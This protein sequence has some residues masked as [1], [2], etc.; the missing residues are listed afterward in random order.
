MSRTFV[1]LNPH[2]GKGRGRKIEPRI[3]EIFGAQG[4]EFGLT[5][6][7][8]DEERLTASAIASGFDRI[9]AV[10][11]D[12]TTSNIGHAIMESGRPVALGLVPGGTGCDL[13]RSLDIPQNDLVRCAE[14][15]AAGRV[16]SIDVGRV[17]GRHFLNVAGFG[18][19][20]AVLERSFQVRWLR[21]EL[22]YLYCALLEMKAYPGFALRSVLDDG[23]GPSGTHMMVIVANAR[24]FGGGFAIA[25]EASLDDGAL[26][27]VSFGDLGFFARL[28]AMSALIKGRHN[29]LPGIATTRARR[30]AFEFTAPPTFETD[31]EWRQ[32]KSASLIIETLPK[33]LRVLVP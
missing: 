30:A 12:G 25:P 6:Q 32:A 19:D 28:K 20:M 10:G 27:I 26:D 5:A 2:S 8:G 16:R 7:A 14:I 15:I 17:E 22:L 13:A 23:P 4:A 29:G 21:G 33:A 1:I 24:K 18:F 9:V 11:G 3:R 31:G